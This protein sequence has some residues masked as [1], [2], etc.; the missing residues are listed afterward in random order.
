MSEKRNKLDCFTTVLYHANNR[1]DNFSFFESEGVFGH[2]SED[3]GMI[4]SFPCGSADMLYKAN[5]RA[6]CIEI[7]NHTCASLFHVSIGVSDYFS[8]L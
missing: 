2:N 3:T 6:M 4:V 8:K 5:I 7:N 1:I